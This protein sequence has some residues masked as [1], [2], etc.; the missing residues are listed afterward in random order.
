MK[1][2]HLLTRRSFSIGLGATM[3]AQ[4]VGL[5]STSLYA[6]SLHK[7]DNSNYPAHYASAAS[8]HNNQ[9]YVAIFNHEG[10]QLSKLKL[11]GRAHQIASCPLTQKLAI[12]ARRPGTFLHIVD[13]VSGKLLLEIQP[14]TGHHFYGHAVYSED[15]HYLYTSENHIESG[16][17]RIFVR[18]AFADYRVVQSFPSYGIGPHEIKFFID[19]HTL[20]VAN[21]GIL[22]HPDS[23]R[24]K[25]NIDIMKPSLTYI[26]S[27]TGEL[28]EQIQLPK[29]LHKLSIRH[30]DINNRGYVAIA[31]QY[32]GDK[33]DNVPLIG[34]H[35]Q[36]KPIKLLWAPE[37]INRKLKNYCGSVCFNKA[38]N[39]FAVSSPRGNTITLW[40]SENAEFITS[41][42]CSDVCGISQAPNNGFNFSNG[43]GK[44]YSFELNQA[45][46]SLLTEDKTLAWDNHLT[47]I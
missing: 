1:A 10:A 43:F 4:L 9:H 27:S 31:M 41:L 17:G 3:G 38:G 42:D 24:A 35:Q 30:I 19:K 5:S 23:G 29:N 36:G 22:T 20:V 12:A 11:P 15:G 34:L 16:E 39:I 28:L 8:D 45:R 33:T 46:L 26:N 32:E 37:Y 2:K 47:K 21:G 44:L 13:S 7:T 6:A 25:L 40:D 14:E 18:D